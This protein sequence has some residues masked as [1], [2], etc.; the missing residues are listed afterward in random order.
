MKKEFIIMIVFF[1]SALAQ[2]SISIEGKIVSD[3]TGIPI[4]YADV[5][6]ENT[7]FY[8][9]TDQTG[10]FNLVR[11]PDGNYILHCS[12]I[13]YKSFTK[14][15]TISKEEK[16]T[17]VI[18][19]EEKPLIGE[20]IVVTAGKSDWQIRKGTRSY[21][22][23][24]DSLP[25]T[26]NRLTAAL[27]LLPGI[28][29]IKNDAG[30]W[31]IISKGSLDKHFKILLDGVD[32][33]NNQSGEVNLD[34]IP[35]DIIKEIEFTP[36]GNSASYGSRAIG[37]IINLIPDYQQKNNRINIG[38]GSLDFKSI[39]LSTN[40]SVSNLASFLIYAQY[41]EA[42]N[43]FDYEYQGETHKRT[44][45]SFVN[46]TITLQMKDLFKLLRLEKINSKQYVQ[47]MHRNHQ[48]PGSFYHYY[49]PNGAASTEDIIIG[50][51]GIQANLKE[52][53][54]WN[55]DVN[56][57]YYSAEYDGKHEKSFPYW[58]KS[59]NQELKVST[60][61]KYIV[62]SFLTLNQTVYY[63]N[64]RISIHNFLVPSLRLTAGERD[65]YGTANNISFFV[66]SS[67][68]DVNL[69][70]ASRF[71]HHN[72]N[73][74]WYPHFQ[75]ST[76]SRFHNMELA[77]TA[78]YSKNFNLPS[79]NSLFWVSSINAVGNPDLKPEIGITRDIRMDLNAGIIFPFKIYVNYFH[80]N[81]N[82]YILWRPD[83]RGTWRPNNVGK[84][85]FTGWNTGLMIKPARF[86][87]ISV[88]YFSQDPISLI[89]GPNSYY[90]KIPFVFTHQI[91]SGFSVNFNHLNIGI[92]YQ[93]NSKRESLLSNTEGTQLRSFEKVDFSISKVKKIKIGEM[94][95]SIDVH[96][97]FNE[98][99]ELV[100]GYPMPGRTINFST[101]L[102]F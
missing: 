73:F 82:D 10:Y 18:R 34:I 68:V 90:K 2:N 88:D 84:T 54:S 99:Y 48:I 45:N 20:T 96:N 89:P 43:N 80:N 101:V 31:K 71:Q 77:T 1:L 78:T 26:T 25:V 50:S 37:G 62:N 6:L 14:K 28:T 87:D 15:V 86:M 102:T 52:K 3:N 53:W 91:K 27:G 64:E 19:L 9:Q 69:S 47:Y 75:I 13:G 56:Y 63:N 44:N 12:I 40:Q 55:T 41:E 83:F 57:K 46:K 61:L 29:I 22:L 21:V 38:I 65:Y 66:S 92:F 35:D 97:I 58:T 30:N 17:T 67:A 36:V 93:K 4:A 59:V 42:G 85:R 7:P 33:T 76:T 5:W 39:G 16:I 51:T 60:S 32:I 24:L 70:F 98:Q 81:L 95:M 8:T 72:G 79:L 74:S 49:K 11:V 94:S 100:I 23:S